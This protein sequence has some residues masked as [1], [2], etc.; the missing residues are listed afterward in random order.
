ML[1]NIVLKDFPKASG[2]YWITDIKGKV[3]YVGS[4]KNLY[5][6]M[7][8]HRSN[9]KAGGSN[10]T[11]QKD[12]YEF[13]QKNEFKVEFKLTNEYRKDEQVLIE[14]HSPR[15]NQ[16]VAYTGLDTSDT[17]SYQKAWH[18]LHKAEE[19]AYQ[20]AYRKA[21]RNQK[22]IYNGKILTLGSLIQR[23]HRRG[24]PHPNIEAKKY[25]IIE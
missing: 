8:R 10:G 14:K 17:K 15:F 3:I 5:N 19:K 4:S 22:C 25:L 21:Y 9:I 2:V 16:K 7:Q 20:M 12:F 11:S 18:E 1:S 6:R 13:L 23:F 24:I